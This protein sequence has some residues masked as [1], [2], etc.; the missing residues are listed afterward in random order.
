MQHY[1]IY[2][3]VRGVV[4]K[5]LNLRS[6]ARAFEVEKYAVTSLTN[7]TTG[8]GD[9]S[10]INDGNN[11]GNGNAAPLELASDAWFD[12]RD[13]IFLEALFNLCLT[14]IIIIAF[15]LGTTLLTRDANSLVV[16]PIERMTDIVRKLAGKVFFLS[17]QA[18]GG[19]E[20]GTNMNGGVDSADGEGQNAEDAFN[21]ETAVVESLV[22]KMAS[23]F[24]VGGKGN[25]KGKGRSQMPLSRSATMSTMS[26]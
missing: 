4:E 14:L 6:D 3:R 9:S 19:G 13:D 7:T 5:S 20:G 18:D 24:D 17:N 15:G 25:K 26:T 2:L 1:R 23:M 22:D 11:N 21:Y 10:A 12:V 8:D 16:R